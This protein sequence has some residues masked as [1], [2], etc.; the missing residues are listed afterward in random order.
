MPTQLNTVGHT[1]SALVDMLGGD[2][3][4]QEW[5][6]DILARVE[7][8]KTHPSEHLVQETEQRLAQDLDR[9]KESLIGR[10]SDNLRS[11]KFFFSGFVVSY[12]LSLLLSTTV[13]HRY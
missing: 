10:H 12:S 6:A 8:L 11:E 13:P 7:Q 1:L 9:V 2:R 4:A 5:S 3:Y